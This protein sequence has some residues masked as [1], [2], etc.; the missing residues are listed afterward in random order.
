MAEF[1]VGDRVKYMVCGIERIG[2]VIEND[3]SDYRPLKIQN[4]RNGSYGWFY[5]EDVSLINS[6]TELKK[7]DKVKIISMDNGSD[8]S[9][10]GKIGTVTHIEKGHKYP[11]GVIID[12]LIRMYSRGVLEKVEEEKMEEENT[13]MFKVG[14]RVKW[15]Y[16]GYSGT[17][18]IVKRGSSDRYQWYVKRDTTGWPLNDVLMLRTSDLS[19]IDYAVTEI[20]GFKIGDSVVI[21]GNGFVG[22]IIEF[23]KNTS[24]GNIQVIVENKEKKRHMV[25]TTDVGKAIIKSE[26]NIGDRVRWTYANYHGTGVIIEHDTSGHLQEWRVKVEVSNGYHGSNLW[27]RNGEIKN[28]ES[29]TEYHGFHVSDVVAV[30][31]SGF[32]GKIAEFS[33]A[34]HPGGITVVVM[35]D[36]GERRGITTTNIEKALSHKPTEKPRLQVGDKVKVV[37]GGNFVGMTGT[38]VK[39]DRSDVPFFVE[40]PNGRERWFIERNLEKVEDVKPESTRLKVGAR[41]RVVKDKY[42]D[43]FVGKTGVI[44]KDDQ[45]SVPFLVRFDDGDVSIGNNGTR[46]FFADELVKIEDVKPVENKIKV[47]DTVKV[48]DTDITYDAEFIGKTGTVTEINNAG[49]MYPVKIQFEG[50]GPR[51]FTAKCLEKVAEKTQEE[52]KF[53]VGDKVKIK[54]GW[55]RCNVGTISMDDGTNCIPYRVVDGNGEFILWCNSNNL[56]KVEDAK[57]VDDWRA[58]FEAF[59]ASHP[60]GTKVKITRKVEDP[61]CAKWVNQIDGTVG[62]IGEIE[63]FEMSGFY[64]NVCVKFNDGAVWKYPMDALEDVTETNQYTF[65]VKPSDVDLDRIWKESN[66]DFAIVVDTDKK[67]DHVVLLYKGGGSRGYNCGY[68]LRYDLQ[69]TINQLKDAYENEKKQRITVTIY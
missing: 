33:N 22:K 13:E 57:P 44:I 20:D 1:K 68:Y 67:S 19:L 69:E 49:F 4:E 7:G 46:W 41:V 17:G 30:K 40:L 11:I 27:L 52:R 18:V 38:I 43:R 21:K 15:T 25:I 48:V 14:D 29:I 36:R 53:K 42:D 23:I 50:Y 66:P 62:K 8:E 58:R 10:L 2:T 54:A 61:H 34:N 26:F 32:T 16:E 28:V 35:N 3:G 31:G 64:Y 5:Y 12:G 24:H 9:Y 6:R 45:T 55:A 59:K 63:K 37:S 60:V 51:R 39:D 56:E 47:G 65:T